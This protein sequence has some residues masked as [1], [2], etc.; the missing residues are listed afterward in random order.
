MIMSALRRGVGCVVTGEPGAGKTIV[1]RELKRRLDADGRITHLVLATAAAQFPLQSIGETASAVP[2]VLLVDDAH[3]LDAYSAA[4]VRHLAVTG[5]ALVVATV[6]SG[7]QAPAGI[8]RPCST[9]A[10]DRLGLEP[11]RWPAGR[12]GRRRAT[13]ASLSRRS[14]SSTGSS[15][16][17]TSPSSSAALPCA[18]R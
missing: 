12:C 14:A 6:R 17:T 11:S 2:P 1:I 7:V 8:E 3:P 5:A 13:S 16:F 9:D 15:C 10:C 4:L 18:V